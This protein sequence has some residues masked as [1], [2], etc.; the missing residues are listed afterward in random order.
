MYQRIMPLMLIANKASP[1]VCTTMFIYF[2]TFIPLIK[3]SE[4]IERRKMTVD[5]FFLISMN[6]VSRIV[7]L[8]EF[9]VTWTVFF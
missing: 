7:F 2:L 8:I 9:M 6:L 4:K 1:F 3:N 5:D